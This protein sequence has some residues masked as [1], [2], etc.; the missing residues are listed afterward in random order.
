MKRMLPLMGQHVIVIVASG[1]QDVGV[2][3]DNAGVI[4]PRVDRG[5]QLVQSSI[6]GNDLGGWHSGM[7]DIDRLPSDIW[8]K[9]TLSNRIDM[10]LKIISIPP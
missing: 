6:I 8:P 9:E 5:W 10:S 7:E 2:D 4:A 1:V 3:I